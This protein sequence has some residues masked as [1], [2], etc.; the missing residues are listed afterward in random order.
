MKLKNLRHK[1]GGI[2]RLQASGVRNTRHEPV[3][4]DTS[5][6][7]LKNMAILF[8]LLNSTELSDLSQAKTAHQSNTWNKLT[9]AY[10]VY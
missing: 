2:A 1:A 3:A 8:P 10:L 4:Q 9:T 6:A 5:S 7:T